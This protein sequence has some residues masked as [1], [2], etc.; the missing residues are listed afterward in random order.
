[1]NYGDTII[2]IINA[3][4]H[5]L[6]IKTKFSRGSGNQVITD[7]LTGTP[8]TQSGQLSWNTTGVSSGKYYYICSPHATFGMGGSIIVE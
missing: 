2:F 6:Y 8:G 3:S 7:K 4:R 1:M 5:P